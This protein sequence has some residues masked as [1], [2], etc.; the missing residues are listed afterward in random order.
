[1]LHLTFQFISFKVKTQYKLHLVITRNVPRGTSFFFCQ[2]LFF[3]TIYAP[4]N[5]MKDDFASRP[6]Q[7]SPFYQLL[8]RN[9]DLYR[10]LS[11]HMCS[12]KSN[13][14]KII[15]NLTYKTTTSHTHTRVLF[16]FMN[17]NHDSVNN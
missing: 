16:I 1:M 3:Y 4:N 6:V 12:S 7:F 17:G 2:I 11:V 8:T 13:K 10:S 14:S 15:I 5:V 9:G